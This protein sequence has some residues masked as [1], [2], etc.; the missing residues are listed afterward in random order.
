MP[1]ARL[2]Y[3]ARRIVQAIPI[4]LAI[5]VLNF[6]LLKLAPGDAVDVLAGEAGSA[7]PE[8]MAEL[9]AKFGLDQPLPVQL[10]RYVGQIATGDFGYSFRHEMPV[11]DLIV[12]RLGP[13]AILMVTTIVLAVGV[14]VLLGLLA[15]VN[16]NTWKD[17][18]ISIL[19]LV[20]YATPL[21]WVG[22]MLIVVFSINLGW[23]PTSGME[24]VAAFYEGW[25][26]V[27][28]IAHHLVLPAI[29]LSLFYLALYTRL[30]RASMLEQAG[31]DYV[32]TA[33]AKGVKEGR[34]TFKHIL[35]NALLPVLTM[36]GVQ[37]S[38]MIGGSVIVET[39]FGWPGLGQL[40]FESLFARDLNLLLGIFFLSAVL[41]LVVNL[42]VDILYTF[43]DPRI[44]L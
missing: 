16:L 21:F 11:W 7:T 3:V 9:R 5:V 4:L 37:V 17:S 34:I 26:R 18:V 33:R 25:D 1:N 41:V 40:A 22:L 32:T 39:V 12:D 42:L 36:A 8:Y 6:C 38:A 2:R 31:M 28:D 29:T 10:V 27:W 44:E 43:L 15:A 35:R 19:A 14:G 24:N 30:M 13:T 23:F 20:S